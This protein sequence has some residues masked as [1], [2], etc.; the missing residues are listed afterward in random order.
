MGGNDS[1]YDD[2]NQRLVA[3]ADFDGPTRHRKC[4]DILC[5]LLLWAMWGCMT[6]LGIYAV[7]NGDYRL[8][9]YPLDYDGNIWYEATSHT[10]LS[11][12]PP[13]LTSSSLFAQ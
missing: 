5:L 7:Q 9:V 4:T 12:D 2:D 11:I 13:D 3:A 10:S 1:R 6:A 8:V